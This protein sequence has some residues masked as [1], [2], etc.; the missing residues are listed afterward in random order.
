MVS[1][2]AGHIAIVF[3]AGKQIGLRTVEEFKKKGYKV[4][5]VAR[6]L[7]AGER[8]GVLYI[9][10]DLTS[11]STVGDTFEAVRQR[12]GEPSVVIYNGK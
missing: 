4:A 11:L 3:G 6:S 10:A 12:W 8:D 9:P 5:A 2:M 7:E 1:I